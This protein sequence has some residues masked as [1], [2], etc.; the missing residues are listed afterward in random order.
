M[1]GQYYKIKSIDG[2][3]IRSLLHYYYGG[4]STHPN[5]N[6]SEWQFD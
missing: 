1:Q 4:W 6:L 2:R 3:N 5:E